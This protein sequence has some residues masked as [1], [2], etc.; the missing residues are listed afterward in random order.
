MYISK[1]GKEFL[2]IEM[3]NHDSVYLFNCL[4]LGLQNIPVADEDRT[5][6]KS[7]VNQLKEIIEAKNAN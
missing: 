7:F 1:N 2:T 6:Y 5:R 4:A 3:D